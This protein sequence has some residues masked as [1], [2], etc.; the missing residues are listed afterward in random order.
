VFAAK[1]VVVGGL[2]LVLGE[3]FAFVTFFLGQ[4]MLAAGH[5]DVRL[6]DPGVLRA[7]LSGGLYLC[8]VTLVGFGLG[9]IIR[10]SAGAIAAM[11]ALIYLAYGA[12]RAVEG[13]SWL[14]ALPGETKN[15]SA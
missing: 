12:A 8:T 15:L 10:H 2:S 3:L 13:W 4:F 7:V 9:A 5:L 11:F 1:A 6:G 14:A